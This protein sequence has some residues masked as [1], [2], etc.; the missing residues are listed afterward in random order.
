MYK[1]KPEVHSATGENIVRYLHDHKDMLLSLP[2]SFI[3]GDFHYENIVVT[4]DGKVGVIDFSSFNTPYGNSWWDFNQIAWMTAHYPYFYSGQVN[5]Y[6]GDKVPEK[7]WR[8][9]SYYMAYDALAALT[10]PYELNG[11]EDGAYVVNNIFKWTNSFTRRIPTWYQPP[12]PAPPTLQPIQSEQD[13]SELSQMAQTITREYFIPILGKENADFCADTYCTPTA[14]AE[15]IANGNAAYFI[16]H[17]AARV[18]YVQYLLQEDCLFIDKLY[19]LPAYR[20]RGIGARVIR[21]IEEIATSSER[22]LL[23]LEAN[24]RNTAAI[25]F[26]EH[27][28][29]A[30]AGECE[31]NDGSVWDTCFLEKIAVSPFSA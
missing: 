4:P 6:F 24:K 17:H 1:T 20:H 2:I 26:Y 15:E 10:D 31:D 28:G 8:V 12:T 9:L 11:I 5:G 27:V 14:L 13:I 19:L 3:H 23:R 25:A 7:F 16:V 21:M 30:V 18:G 22:P 29:F